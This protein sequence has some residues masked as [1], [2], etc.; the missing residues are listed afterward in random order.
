MRI[1]NTIKPNILSSFSVWI[2]IALDGFSALAF[3]LLCLLLAFIAEPTNLNHPSPHAK[4]AIF[5][6]AGS[7]A[8]LTFVY[9]VACYI[10]LVCWQQGRRNWGYIILGLGLIHL[11]GSAYILYFSSEFKFIVEFLDMFFRSLAINLLDLFYGSLV[12]NLL[13]LIIIFIGKIRP[14]SLIQKSQA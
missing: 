4:D 9:L 13:L 1:Q 3:G 5:L 14:K 12:I 7:I 11:V 8:L 6:W 10:S 2:I